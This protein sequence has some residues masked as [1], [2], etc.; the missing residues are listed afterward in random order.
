M[1]FDRTKAIKV[2]TISEKAYV[3][4]S[5][6]IKTALDLRPQVDMRHLALQFGCVRLIG[7]A[8]KTFGMYKKRFTEG[9]P[10]AR[11]AGVDFSRPV[12]AAV[13]FY[14]TA[15]KNKLKADVHELVKL[16]GTSEEEFGS[17]RASMVNLCFDLV[18]VAKKKR[19]ADDVKGNRYLLDA[20]VRNT[21]EG[22]ESG[23]DDEDPEEIGQ[24]DDEAFDAL[25]EMKKSRKMTKDREY[26]NW[27]S[28][29]LEAKAAIAAATGLSETSKKGKRQ[30]VLKFSKEG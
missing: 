12:F 25:P 18:G 1:S 3:R 9:L 17:V 28:G 10:E 8:Q 24:V 19:A 4:S 11:R 5:M 30:S 20:Q 15:R 14:L 7:S 29:V 2:S 21:A 6:A 26:R 23:S 27:M 22:Q 13:A 16:C